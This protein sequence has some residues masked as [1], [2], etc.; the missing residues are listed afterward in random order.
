MFCIKCGSK[1]AQGMAFCTNCGAKVETTRP[2]SQP[3]PSSRP[4]PMPGPVIPGMVPTAKKKRSLLPLWITL[5]VIG[6]VIIAVVLIVT[7]P[8]VKKTAQTQPFEEAAVQSL[9]TPVNETL[10]AETN[11]PSPVI[12]EMNI[13]VHFSLLEEYDPNDL[14]QSMY[15]IGGTLSA[16]SIVVATDIY[17]YP[18]MDQSFE[19]YMDNTLIEKNNSGAFAI[20]S[21]LLAQSPV[22]VRI[23]ALSSKGEV[24]DSVQMPKMMV[25][26]ATEAESLSGMPASTLE[27]QSLMVFG[28]RGEDFSSLSAITQLKNLLIYQCNGIV[29]I[30]TFGRLTGLEYLDFSYCGGIDDISAIGSFS[31]LKSLRFYDCGNLGNIDPLA[32]LPGLEYLDLGLSVNVYNIQSLASISALEYVNLN[33]IDIDGLQ[34]LSSASN[35]QYLN[36][37]SASGYI[38]IDAVAG[39]SQLKYL[40]LHGC[41]GFSSIGTLAAFRKLEY[42]NVNECYLEDLSV[43]GDLSMLRFLDVRESAGDTSVRVT[44]YTVLNGLSQLEHLYIND[45]YS[46]AANAT[47][48]M[49]NLRYLNLDYCYVQH[50]DAFLDLSKLEELILNECRQMEDMSGLAGLTSLKKLYLHVSNDPIDFSYLNGSSNLEEVNVSYCSVRGLESL[51]M[52]KGLTYLRLHNTHIEDISGLKGL[53][54]LEYLDISKNY[55]I[56][57]ISILLELP[58]LKTLNVKECD[59]IR[60]ESS[61]V[62]VLEELEARGCEVIR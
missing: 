59:R 43:I 41:R 44:D 38:N 30:D 39:A 37:D 54:N 47:Y 55:A 46:C 23:D 5:S 9:E 60:S 20:D 18:S 8:S 34:S 13:N 45:T 11:P 40:N 10:V 56:Y 52:H 50:M 14:F 22:T 51:A 15:H 32:S 35:L 33:D 1:I 28:Y 42:L 19:L 27:A 3:A 2:T 62:A 26:D 12:E 6:A 61:A 4:A 31:K 21:A 57:D 48:G 25:F 24:M 36:L 16:D 29:S 17:G 49:E 58:N 53:E 7:I